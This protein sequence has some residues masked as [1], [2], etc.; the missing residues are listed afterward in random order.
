MTSLEPGEKPAPVDV[1][2]SDGV[3][4]RVRRGT[5]VAKEKYA[6]SSAEHLWHRL[7]SM[8]FMNRGMLF[9]ATL[10]L[11]FFPFIIVANAL[12]GQTAANGLARHL[13]LNK[14]ASADMAQLFTSSSATSSAITGTAWVVVHSG[15]SGG[16]HRHPTAV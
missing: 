3:G 16:G 15:R 5:E 2:K 6:G 11:C 14:Q 8:D 13:G 4:R 12:A 10:L 7:D 9:A 1:D